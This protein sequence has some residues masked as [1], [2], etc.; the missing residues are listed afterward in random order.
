MDCESKG[1]VPVRLSQ[2]ASYFHKR[3]H[4]QA[5]HETQVGYMRKFLKISRKLAE[6]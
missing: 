5:F 2:K 1:K 4:I 6:V 3:L